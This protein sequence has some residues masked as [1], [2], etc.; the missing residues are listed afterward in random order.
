VRREDNLIASL[1]AELKASQMRSDFFSEQ[2]VRV[3]DEYRAQIKKL[4]KHIKNL[5]KEQENG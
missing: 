4:E 1:K 2:L 5:T 3:S